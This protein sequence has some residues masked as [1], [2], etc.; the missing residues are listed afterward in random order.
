MEASGKFI[1]W[2]N[3]LLIFLACSK[4]N[5]PKKRFLAMHTCVQKKKFLEKYILEFFI[6]FFYATTELRRSFLSNTRNLFFYFFWFFCFFIFRQGDNH[7]CV[8]TD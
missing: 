2:E 8:Q 5:K 7:T 1:L 6:T 3:T 4:K